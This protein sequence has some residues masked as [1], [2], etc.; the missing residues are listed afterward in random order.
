MLFLT[1]LVHTILFHRALF[2]WAGGG[3]FVET[4]EL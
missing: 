3:C 1:F 4:W 2:M